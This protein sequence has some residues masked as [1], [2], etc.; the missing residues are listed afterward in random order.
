MFSFTMEMLFH[1]QLSL[2]LYAFYWWWSEKYWPIHCIFPDTLNAACPDASVRYHIMS[3]RKESDTIEMSGFPVVTDTS[4]IVYWSLVWYDTYG[5]P[6]HHVRDT[7][8]QD[9]HARVTY[10]PSETCCVLLRYYRSGIE[11]A[12]L[13][14]VRVR[15]RDL[16]QDLS[17]KKRQ[18]NMIGAMVRLVSR[19]RSWRHLPK[20][21]FF[22]PDVSQMHGIFPNPDAVY[23]VCVPTRR[24]E[25][26][27]V[28]VPTYYKT[29]TRF[30]GLMTCDLATT[31]TVMSTP[32]LH[33]ATHG[34]TVWVFV[35]SNAVQAQERG[36]DSTNPT[37]C[38]LHWDKATCFP[39]LVYRRITMA[40]AQDKG[41]LH[42]VQNEK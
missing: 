32:R 15:G 19:L 6:I 41:Y 18:S 3:F 17:N 27:K 34:K 22:S 38:L 8:V 13:P 26:I 2:L 14:V 37:H 36:Y 31:R 42:L 20:G 10:T 39:I 24:E 30:I 16:A 25:C 40:P 4:P 23:R 12:A 1:R 33:P 28:R 5:L 9:G 29:S 35:C 21:K 11:D 7:D